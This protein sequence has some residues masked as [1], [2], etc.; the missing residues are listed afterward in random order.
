MVDVPAFMLASKAGTEQIE[1]LKE[2][3]AKDFADRLDEASSRKTSIYTRGYATVA[4]KP[5]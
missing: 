3:E 2:D 1:N 4:G 5:A